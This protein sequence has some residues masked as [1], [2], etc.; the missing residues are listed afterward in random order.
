MSTQVTCQ[1]QDGRTTT[2]INYTTI[3]TAVPSFLPNLG[4]LMP[5]G[6]TLG[7]YHIQS[8]NGWVYIPVNQMA[9]LRLKPGCSL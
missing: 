7:T 3:V 6:P 4:A 5:G 2:G 8:L 9:A 1:T